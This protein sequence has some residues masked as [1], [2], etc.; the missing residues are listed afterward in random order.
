MDV[1]KKKKKKG[2][3]NGKALY[4]STLYAQCILQVACYIDLQDNR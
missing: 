4:I 2:K 1:Q 3:K